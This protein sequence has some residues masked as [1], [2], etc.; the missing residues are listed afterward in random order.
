[1]KIIIFFR[2]VVPLKEGIK[3]MKEYKV[4]LHICC[5]NYQVAG[6]TPEPRQLY[7][8]HVQA[9]VRHL[10]VDEL[11]V[12]VGPRAPHGA[13]PTSRLAYTAILSGLRGCK[14]LIP[15]YFYDALRRG[16]RTVTRLGIKC[17]GTLAD[18]H[19]GS[20]EATSSRHS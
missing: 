10:Q 2:I 8:Q 13:G 7:Q 16:R 6:G 3:S 17:G 18:L 1:M 19:R 12:V 9:K 14:L 20:W 11:V 5:G 15:S 4:R